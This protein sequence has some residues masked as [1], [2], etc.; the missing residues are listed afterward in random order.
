MVDA[1]P[2]AAE[3]LSAIARFARVASGAH[4]DP[5]VGRRGTTIIGTQINGS[6]VLLALAE[7][8]RMEA[9]GEARETSVLPS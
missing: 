3:S 7:A 8:R 6:D 9:E 1:L 4:L 5:T 2:V